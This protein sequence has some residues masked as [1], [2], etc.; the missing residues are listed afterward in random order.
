MI[1]NQRGVQKDKE[2]FIPVDFNWLGYQHDPFILAKQVFYI[3]DPIDKKWHIVLYDKRRIVGVGNIVDE[4]D[5]HHFDEIRPFSTDIE[6]VLVTN[7]D[8]RNYLC[9]DHE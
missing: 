9:S 5:Y 8:E 3:V 1:E 4:D 7:N 6:I 2:G